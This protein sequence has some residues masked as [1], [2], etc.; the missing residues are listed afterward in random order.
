MFFLQFAEINL[1]APPYSKTLIT[2]WT[3]CPKAKLISL[4]RVHIFN[5]PLILLYIDW[6]LWTSIK[7]SCRLCKPL[8]I[9]FLIFLQFAEF[10]Q[11]APPYSKTLITWELPYSRAP[12]LLRSIYSQDHENSSCVNV[13][14]EKW[15]FLTSLFIY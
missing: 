1:K 3:Y 8:N 9:G 15:K 13:A 4:Y 2:Q 10:N 12:T 11:K 5:L 14:L 6:K 7:V